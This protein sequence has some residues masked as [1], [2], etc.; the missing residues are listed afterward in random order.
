LNTQISRF[1][2][3]T[4]GRTGSTRLRLLLDSHPEI[5]CHGEVFGGN[6]STLAEPD[7]PAMEEAEAARA[8]SPARFMQE[9]VFAAGTHRAVG[10]KVLYEQMFERWPGLVEAL[11]ADRSIR[12]VHLV[13]RNGL[14]RFMSEY[15]VG[16]VTHKHSVLR[17]EPLPDIQP[18]SIHVPSLLEN[19]QFLEHRKAQTRKMFE[20]H[21]WH[22]I[23]YEDSAEDDS[24][25]LDALL[26]F[27]QVPRAPLTVGTRKILPEELSHL[28]ANLDEVTTALRGTPFEACLDTP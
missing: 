3:V 20:A 23:A 15:F 2:I 26:D 1:V 7:S 19:L 9:W 5:R 18:V 13:R 21:P 12:I 24:P 14:K 25:A 10:F 16:T 28:L 4:A 17:D 22:E 11:A 8:A 6:L 27:L